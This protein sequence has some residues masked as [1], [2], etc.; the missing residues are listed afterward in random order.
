MVCG[1][2]TDYH[3]RAPMNETIVDLLFLLLHILITSTAIYSGH[4][5]RPHISLSLDLFLPALSGL[6]LGESVPPALGPWLL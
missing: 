1:L 3:A 5:H 2:K 4:C 6:S